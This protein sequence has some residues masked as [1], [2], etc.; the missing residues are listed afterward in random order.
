MARPAPAAARAANIVSFLTAH[1]GRGYT[2]SE[3]VDHLGMNIASAHATL[4]VLCDLG[5]TLRDPQHRTYVL[6]PALAVTGFAALEQH[7]AIDAAIAEAERLA[8]ELDTEVGVSAIAGRDVIFVAR[9]GPQPLETSVGYAGDRSPLL[10]PF[11]AVYMAW[12]DE[13]TVEGWLDRASTSA[14]VR[15]FY[16]NALADIRSRGFSVPFPSITTD[17]VVAA[18]HRLREQPTDERVEEE[19]T[20]ALRASDEV[21]LSFE[22]LSDSD[23]I[24]I[25]TVAAPIFD[26][27]GRVLLAI[28]ITGP[29]HKIRVDQVRALGQRLVK[30]ASVATRHARGRI[31]EG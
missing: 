31:P 1:A 11:G 3:L 21:L 16:L 9:T 17:H 12:A 30:S 7:P 8:D 5:F 4:A 2:I 25:K 6:G 23:E 26:P 18:I 29:A 20:D 27:I 22:G 28:S 19:L 15:D 13:T 14:K 24:F 10:A